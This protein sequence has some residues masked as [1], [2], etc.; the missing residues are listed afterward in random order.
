MPTRRPDSVSSRSRI[1][2]LA[3]SACLLVVQAQQLALNPAHAADVADTAAPE[4]VVVVT[5]VLPNSDVPLDEVPANIQQI[6]GNRLA[7]EKPL[8]ISQALDQM[9]GSVNVN[10]TQGNP[11]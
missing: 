7:H 5:A 1:S 6:G 4:T 9:V 3:A 8:N 2:T 10:D 11:T